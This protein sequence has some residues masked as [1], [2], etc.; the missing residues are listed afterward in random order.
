MVAV[1]EQFLLVTVSLMGTTD[2]LAGLGVQRD[3][4]RRDASAFGVLDDHGLSGFDDCGNRVG[5]SKVDSDDG[6]WHVGG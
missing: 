6:F 3:D 1:W 2:D 4:G 5:G